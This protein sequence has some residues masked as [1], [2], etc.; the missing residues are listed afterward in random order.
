MLSSMAL[1]VEESKNWSRIKPKRIHHHGIMMPETNEN[2]LPRVVMPP[3]NLADKHQRMEKSLPSLQSR[4][5]GFLFLYFSSSSAYHHFS[6]FIFPSLEVDFYTI[7]TWLPSRVCLWNL[8][9]SFAFKW[10]LGARC[11]RAEAKINT[12]LGT[13]PSSEMILWKLV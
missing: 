1:F 11:W 2:I 3:A 9:N 12:K 8:I 7:S 5:A 6:F 10:V 13:F 4:K